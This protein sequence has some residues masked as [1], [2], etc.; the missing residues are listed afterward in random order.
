LS[1]RLETEDL[2]WYVAYGSNMRAARFGCYISGGRPRGARRMC[3]AVL[4]GHVEDRLAI[5]RQAAYQ[6]FGAVT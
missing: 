6:P 5:T 1:L 3:A 4:V 2:V